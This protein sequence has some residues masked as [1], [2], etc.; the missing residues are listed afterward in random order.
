MLSIVQWT[1]HIAAFY[2]L[3]Q[4]GTLRGWQRWV[5][6]TSLELLRPVNQTPK[7]NTHAQSDCYRRVA[8]RWTCRAQLPGRGAHY[9]CMWCYNT[10]AT[11]S[12]Y[13]ELRAI[14][15]LY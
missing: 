8:A 4:G 14:E 7:R 11:A 10:N 3:N 9:D 6:W 5:A 2:S 12:R 15:G 1:P 13:M